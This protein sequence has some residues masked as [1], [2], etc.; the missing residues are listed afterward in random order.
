LSIK[1]PVASRAFYFSTSY[2]S[3]RPLSNH[4]GYYKV[5]D[6]GFTL[7]QTALESRL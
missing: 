4:Q 1:S 2:L 6:R 5:L 7:Y 3:D